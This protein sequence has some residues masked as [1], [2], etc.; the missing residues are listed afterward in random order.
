M[1]LMEP[2]PTPYDWNFRLFNVPVRVHPFFWVL[3]ALLGWGWFNAL[4]LPYLLLWVACVF[5]S[6][7]IHEL[8]HVFAF[9][10]FGVRA[11]VVLYSFGGLAIPTHSPR[12]RWQRIV[13][14]LAGPGAQLAL[15]LLVWIL[16]FTALPPQAPA[17]APEA[18]V[19]EFEGEQTERPPAR[20]RPRPRPP[21]P[22]ASPAV[23]IGL[24]MMV[25]I[26]LIWALLNL[27]PVWPLDGG[28]V[29]REIMV[30]QS[31]EKGLVNSLW[32]SVI[33]AAVLA[34]HCLLAANGGPG[35]IPFLPI[36]GMYTAIFFA[37]F[38]VQSYQLL[39]ME[40]MRYHGRHDRLPWE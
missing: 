39:Q 5:V 26:N 27:L 24:T 21:Q 29:A 19:E 15:C 28:K 22:A 12:E 18:A 9:Q 13:V 25:W 32:L 7:L 11:H 34:V 40:K 14:S 20:S 31:P 2:N 33:C 38:A 36:G 1:V 10:K 16:S 35:L 3:S 6:I 30:G 4:G 23:V 8:G 37:L 17:R